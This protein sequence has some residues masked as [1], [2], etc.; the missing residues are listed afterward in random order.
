M[1]AE[2]RHQLEFLPG[3]FA[4]CR[5]PPDSEVPEWVPEGGKDAGFSA[6]YSV[7]RTPDELSIIAA[8]S[9]VPA[10]EKSERGFRL[11]RV[12]GTLDFSAVGILSALVAPLAKA[13]IPVLSVSTF[14]TDYLLI[15]NQRVE[16]AVAA[17]REAGHTVEDP[18]AK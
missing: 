17:L 1:S 4:V 5:L 15:R 16:K 9:S 2:S 8:E 13:E 18:P 3:C 14:D 10:A 11:L 12:A 7:T 6:F